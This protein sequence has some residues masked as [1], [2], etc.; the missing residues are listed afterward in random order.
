VCYNACADSCVVYG[1]FSWLG[2]WSYAPVLKVQ[3]SAKTKC[4][5]DVLYLDAMNKKYLEEVSLCN[6]FVVK[7]KTVSTPALH[8]TILPGVTRKSIIEVAHSQGYEVHER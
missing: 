4:F 3:C 8:G 2:T 5:S 6:I 1:R 7:D